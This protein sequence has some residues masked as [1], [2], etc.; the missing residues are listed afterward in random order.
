MEDFE[1]RLSKI[2]NQLS[3][4]FQTI[5]DAESSHNYKVG[6]EEFKSKHGDKL[7]KYEQVAKGFNGDDFDIYNAAY[8]E[9]NNAFSDVEED[10]YIAKLIET[11]DNKLA[12][13]RTA[14]AEGEP[15]EQIEEKVDEAKEV[16][17]EA[18]ETMEE[19]G[20]EHVE[21]GNEEAETGEEIKAETEGESES[22]ETE[23]DAEDGIDEEEFQ[24]QLDEDYEK[25]HS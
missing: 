17:E 11:L 19:H 1:A 20:E 4:L 18:K 15:Q 2:E 5:S 16:A 12:A 24:K 8:D 7:A 13:I 3:E 25:Y 23:A 6:L 21:E 14:V 9:Y 10:T 22:E